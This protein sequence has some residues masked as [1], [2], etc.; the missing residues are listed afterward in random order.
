MVTNQQKQRSNIISILSAFGAIFIVLTM[1]IWPEQTYQGARYGLEL[2]AT[3]L[4][5]SLLP[6]FI[7]T[8]VLLN[9]GVVNML[10]VLLEPIM[11][12]LFNLP[13]SASFVVAMGFTSGF[14]MGAV[15]TRR[16]CE[17]KECTIAEGERLLAFTNNSSP[18][19]IMAAVAVGMFQNVYIGVILA[20]SHYLANI[21][22]GIILGIASPR[23]PQIYYFNKH[24]LINSLKALLQAQQKRKPWAKLL[25]EAI[26]SGINT[27]CLIGGFVI[28]YAIVIRILKIT[29]LL[30]LL[31]YPGN[32]LLQF[33][34][35]TPNLASALATGFWEMTLG[36]KETALSFATVREK[37]VIASIL[38]GWS[39][40]SIQ[41]QVTS[42]LAGSGINPRLYY[43]GR[44]LQ[45][46]MAGLITH[47]L[48]LYDCWSSFLS[49]PVITPILPNNTLLS[50]FSFNFL[51]TCKLFYYVSLALF[52]IS[53]LAIGF[54]YVCNIIAY[55]RNVLFLPFSKAKIHAKKWTWQKR[56]E[57]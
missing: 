30:N 37:A 27:I 54:N 41:S 48:T 2:W 43:Q 39:G 3:V 10:G 15:L 14:P 1:L 46:F 32:V 36:L 57:K 31:I 28:I 6:F 9:L 7:I 45:S 19:F 12:P 22:L 17:E 35:F 16:L 4:V 51:A 52:L 13:G 23:Q 25:S 44:I 26:R 5:P 29:S 49:L 38:L 18:L 8:E 33:L 42:V 34:G 53:C 47:F 20:I 56:D 24:L 50:L 40:L 21:L 55:F 11:R